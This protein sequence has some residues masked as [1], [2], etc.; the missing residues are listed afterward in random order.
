MYHS[1]CFN[2]LYSKLRFLSSRQPVSSNRLGFHRILHCRRF[3]ACW[4][5]AVHMNDWVEELVI[6]LAKG[7]LGSGDS[8]TDWTNANDK[9]LWF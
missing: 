9:T 4:D 2:S 8:S 1:L 5:Y 6:R 7:L 3:G